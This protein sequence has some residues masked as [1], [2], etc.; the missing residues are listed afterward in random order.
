MNAVE[1]FL[2]KFTSINPSSRSND[3]ATYIGAIQMPGI[4]IN[5]ILAVSRCGSAASAPECNPQKALLP[6]RAAVLRK[7]HRLQPLRFWILDFR[8]SIVGSKPN[9]IRAV[10]LLI[11]LSLSLSLLLSF[12]LI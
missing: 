5:R 11:D 2:T 8:F 9:L 3:S 1:G 6:A 7:S 12:S 10:F 4:W